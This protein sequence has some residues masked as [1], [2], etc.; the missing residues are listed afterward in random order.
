MQGNYERVNP[1]IARGKRVI[2]G[3]RS[4]A[5]RTGKM[6]RAGV[7]ARRIVRRIKRSDCH[8][9]WRVGANAGRSG[10][11]VVSSRTHA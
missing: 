7:A 9:E 3:Q 4:A 1:G 5:V 6:Q 10:D 8:I 11:G 2:G